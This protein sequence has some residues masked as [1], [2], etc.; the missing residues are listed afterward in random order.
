M[1]TQ[2]P[3]LNTAGYKRL[4]LYVLARDHYACQIRGPRCKGYAD[5]VDHVID[6]AD[7]GDTFDP[8]N[9]RAACHPCNMAKSA[10]RT[11]DKRRSKAG[12]WVPYRTTEAQAD[13]R[14]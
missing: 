11:T 5:Q 14:L 10:G 1:T 13:T 12:R 6:R 8:A 2:D 9:L 4:R 7:G 3:R